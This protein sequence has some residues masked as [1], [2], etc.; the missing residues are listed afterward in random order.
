MAS[1]TNLIAE[2]IMRISCLSKRGPVFPA[3]GVNPGLLEAFP[4]SFMRFGL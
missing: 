3:A 2:L 1:V 4:E